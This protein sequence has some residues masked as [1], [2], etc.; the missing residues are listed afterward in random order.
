MFEILVPTLQDRFELRDDRAQALP[1]RAF[2]DR[3]HAV[4]HFLFALLTWPFTAPFEVVSQKVK[5]AF[6]RRVHHSRF[7]TFVILRT[8]RSPPVAPHPVSRRRSYLWLQAGERLPGEDLHLSDGVRS[9]AHG[10]RRFQRA[11]S[12]RSHIASQSA[13]CRDC[14]LE[15]ARTQGALPD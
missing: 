3:A 12:A 4:F 7:L 9:Q 15:A 2:G 14:A 13:S 6:L 8:D 1:V 10:A 5:A 11:V